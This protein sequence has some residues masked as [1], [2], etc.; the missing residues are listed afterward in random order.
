ME[1]RILAAADLAAAT[2]HRVA[3]R[4]GRS[5]PPGSTTADRLA[6]YDFSALE[7]LWESTAR[8]RAL[9]VTGRALVRVG[10][11]QA[12]ANQRAGRRLG[13]HRVVRRMAARYWDGPGQEV[14]ANTSVLHLF[15]PPLPFVQQGLAAAH[16]AGVPVLYQSVHEITPEYA[17]NIY[18]K[19]FRGTCNQ[20]D[21][22]LISHPGQVA[23]FAEHFDYQGR[24][25]TISQSA[26]D[27]E[28]DL[29]ELQ[30]ASARPAGEPLVIGTLCRLD[31]VKGLDVLLEAFARIAPGASDV[32]LRIGGTGA[33]EQALRAQAEALGISARVELPGL[34]TDRAAFYAGLDVFAITSRSE[35]GPVTGVEAMAA[36]LPIV[37]TAV[38]AMPDRLDGGLGLLVEVDDVDASATALGRLVADAD[39][40]RS[41]GAAARERYVDRYTERAQQAALTALWDELI[42]HHPAS[43]R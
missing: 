5:T 13:T 43:P 8:S 21:L 27:I 19:G 24:T 35:G 31:E 14:L 37:S 20:L 29:L 34:V 3:I 23:D 22:I 2:G 18:R 10:N 26:L 9:D 42:A 32:V 39:L 33:Q 40:R 11:R 17:A 7:H 15:G 12:I 25:V 36:G 30:R 4:A 16:A 41:L 1:T 38:G 6:A 28:D